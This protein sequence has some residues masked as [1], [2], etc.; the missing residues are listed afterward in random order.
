MDIPIISGQIKRGPAEACASFS[1]K[2]N[3]ENYGGPRYES[4]EFFASRKVQCAPE[5]LTALS[6]ELHQECIEEVEM[7]AKQY[8]LLVKKRQEEFER[9]QA[10][11]EKRRSA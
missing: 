1:R 8:V 10:D 9:R 4:A 6:I 2:V 5:D 7:H 11:K 3:L